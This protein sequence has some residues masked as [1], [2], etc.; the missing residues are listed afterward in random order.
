MR[1]A[2]P[3]PA[4]I[5]VNSM[6]LLIAA[7]CLLWSSAFAVAK[8][9][10]A[11]C[12]PLLLLAA[13]FLLAG[14]TVLLAAV[15]LRAPWHLSRRDVAVLAL[16]GVVNNALY[17]G[18]NYI[19]MQSISAGLS[20]LIVSANPVLTAL[21]AAGFLGERMTWRKAAGL[22]LG[23]GGVAFVVEHRITGGVDSAVGVAFTTAAL[24]SLVGGTILFKKLAPNGGLWIGNG[25][26]N[27]AG[28]LALLPFGLGLES[29]GNVVPTWRLLGALLYMALLVSVFGYLLWFHILT[30]TGATAA[31]AY[32]FLM[33]PLGMMFG[34]MLLGEH[35]AVPDLIGILPVALGI[36]LVTRPASAVAPTF[37]SVSQHI[38]HRIVRAKTALEP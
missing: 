7:F 37:R 13:R 38:L 36:Y 6:P 25:V 2:I 27:L 4:P 5:A 31:S 10:L 24:V 12:P 22:L 30:V 8:L 20:A 26:Q 1:L 19:G 18:L 33:P 14:A 11:D 29:V 9:A 23:V 16:L 17:L 15:V 21:L 32:H 34:W 3:V 35:V 28:G